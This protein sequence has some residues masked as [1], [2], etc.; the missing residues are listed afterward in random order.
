MVLGADYFDCV[1]KLGFADLLLVYEY[2][3]L[4]VIYS[5]L[6]LVDYLERF[7]INVFLKVSSV[8]L[9]WKHCKIHAEL[10]AF[11]MKDSTVPITSDVIVEAET[12]VL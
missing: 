10:N 6:H 3:C 5:F 8:I 7:D 11:S 1:L 4:S 2:R 12:L 9:S